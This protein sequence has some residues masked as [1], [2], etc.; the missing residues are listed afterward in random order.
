MSVY[1]L[2]DGWFGHDGGPMRQSEI[3]WGQ[4]DKLWS[5]SDAA[6]A[7][8]PWSNSAAAQPMRGRS[9]HWEGVSQKRSD[10]APDS[11]AAV[12]ASV[13]DNVK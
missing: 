6:V 9:S 7:A 10:H 13:F 1:G 4:L 11:D 12:F 3:P 5:E 2:T 8:A